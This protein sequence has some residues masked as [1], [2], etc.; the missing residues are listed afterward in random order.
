MPT[1]LNFQDLAE[2]LAASEKVP[3]QTKNYDI[4]SKLGEVLV[5][6]FI[7]IYCNHYIC[8]ALIAI[9]QFVIFEENIYTPTNEVLVGVMVSLCLSVCH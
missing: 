5:N 3:M 8:K 6:R 1:S 9:D 4:D 7:S 2:D